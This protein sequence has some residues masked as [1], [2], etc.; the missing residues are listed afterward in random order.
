MPTIIT[1]TQLRSVLG[2]SSSLYNDDYLNQII[3]S[4]EAVVLPMLVTYSQP[5]SG[6]KLESNVA[7]FYYLG[8]PTFNE[9]QS[10]VISGLGSPFD[11]TRTVTAL[12][13]GYFN[14]AITNA[15]VK[16][17]QI[18]PSGKATLVNAAT[19]VGNDAIESA[20]YVVS[21]EIFQSRTAAGGQIEGVDFAPTPYRMGKSLLSRVSGLL[22]PYLDEGAI[23]Q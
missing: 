21:T 8:E 17:K 5:I 10:V 18:I 14:A 13:D 20:I 6:A 11:G 12:G 15:D 16:F 7:Y 2:V 22:A 9:A 4:A 19:Y 3:D 23:C 1:A